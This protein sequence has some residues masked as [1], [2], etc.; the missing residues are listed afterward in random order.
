MPW[1]GD[2]VNHATDHFDFHPSLPPESGEPPMTSSRIDHAITTAKPHMRIT[3][4]VRNVLTALDDLGVATIPQ[5]LAHQPDLPQS[6][7]YRILTHLEVAGAVLRIPY[8]DRSAFTLANDTPV[9]GFSRC[10]GCGHID[11]SPVDDFGITDNVASILALVTTTAET[12]RHR[13]AVP[14]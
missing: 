14:A 5:L 9:R 1:D 3:R 6:S 8:A 11:E 2:P 7:T 13:E 12:C 10:A 4:T